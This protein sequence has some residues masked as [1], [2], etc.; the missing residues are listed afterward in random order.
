M[1]SIFTVA[2]TSDKSI[3]LTPIKTGLTSIQVTDK[4][5]IQASKNIVIKG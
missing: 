2:S 4:D 1:S 3:I 5:G